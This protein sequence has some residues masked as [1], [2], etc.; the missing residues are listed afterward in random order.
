VG[1]SLD[2]T[3]TGWV[4]A[5]RATFDGTMVGFTVPRG[6]RL[7]LDSNSKRSSDMAAAIELAVAVLHLGPWRLDDGGNTGATRPTDNGRDRR[8]VAVVEAA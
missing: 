4:E 1:I 6:D 2:F 8:A 3:F 7:R 5:T